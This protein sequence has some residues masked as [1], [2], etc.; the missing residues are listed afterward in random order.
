M[1]IP[2]IPEREIR[3]WVTES[4]MPLPKE[5]WPYKSSQ[6]SSGEAFRNGFDRLN[7]RLETT[8]SCAICGGAGRIW[9][10]KNPLTRSQYSL[11]CESCNE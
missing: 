4:E 7:I 5:Q 10:S 9:V 2:V 11:E 8:D 1:G 6:V 3:K